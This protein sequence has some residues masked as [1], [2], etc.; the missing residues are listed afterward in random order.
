MIIVGGLIP[1]KRLE[2]ILSKVINFGPV[3]SDVL[4]RLYQSSK[5]TSVPSFFTEAFGRVIIESIVNGT[6]VIT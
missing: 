2:G 1:K 3:T 4:D 5:I 6:P